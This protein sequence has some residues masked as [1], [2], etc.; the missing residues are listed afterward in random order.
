MRVIRHCRIYS[1]QGRTMSDAPR[2]YLIGFDPEDSRAR[3][4]H[5]KRGG[6]V[7]FVWRGFP[8]KLS[9]RMRLY[10]KG[11]HYTH[12]LPDG[13]IRKPFTING[14]ELYREIAEEKNEAVKARIDAS[15]AAISAAVAPK[16][17]APST[18]A[19]GGEYVQTTL[20]GYKNI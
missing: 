14:S 7:V 2:Y 3:I 1:E 19:P 16:K 15:R 17:P 12:P 6:R 10:P 9:G 13:L 18:P 8:D 4:V 5:E 20:F 11:L